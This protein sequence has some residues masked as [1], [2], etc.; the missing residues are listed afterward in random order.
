MK[1]RMKKIK[2]Q[3]NEINLKKSKKIIIKPY[4]C[5]RKFTGLNVELSGYCV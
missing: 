2:K 3:I 5:E 1:N 4:L